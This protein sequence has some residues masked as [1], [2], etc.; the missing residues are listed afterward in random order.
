MG[1]M[2]EYKRWT[3]LV[4]EPDLSEELKQMDLEKILSLKM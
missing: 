1:Y 2:E 3:E 4:T